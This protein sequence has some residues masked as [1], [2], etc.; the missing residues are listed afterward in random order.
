MANCEM[1]RY[2]IECENY[3]PKS[4]TA[5]EHYAEN[6]QQLKPCPF[7]GHRAELRNTGF[8]VCRNRENGDIITR[9]FV[10]CPYCGTEREG[11]CSEYRIRDDETLR[12]M[13]DKKDGRRRAIENWNRRATERVPKEKE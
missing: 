7:C 4:T 6:V 2:R 9:W 13:D 11:G 10:R 3:A 12:L 5:C 8:E 1:C